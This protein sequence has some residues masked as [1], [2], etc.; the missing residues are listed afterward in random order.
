ASNLASVRDFLSQTTTGM[1]SRLNDYLIKTTDDDGTIDDKQT[2]LGAQSISIDN[3]IADLER[4]VQA[5]RT[6]M[7]SS[8]VT[9]E[10]AQARIN[11]QLQYINQRFG[12]R[13]A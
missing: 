6:A 2:V 1:A 11:Q 7:I 3:Q 13:S 5:R 8:F 4:Q 12:S 9:M 10:Q